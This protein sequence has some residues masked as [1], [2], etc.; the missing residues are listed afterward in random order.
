[1]KYYGRFWI[2]FCILGLFSSSLFASSS[3]QSVE[4]SLN[5]Y[6]SFPPCVPR[7]HVKN[8]RVKGNIVNVYTN[9]T[10][11]C[12]SLS[13]AEL[14]QLHKKVSRWVLG[15][16][17]GKVTLYSDRKDLYS[18]ITARYKTIKNPYTKT[19]LPFI[20]NTDKG[21]TASKGLEGKKIALWP[22]HGLYYNLEQDIWRWQRATM[23]SMVEDV[24]THQLANQWLVPMLENA[25]VYVFEPRERDTQT[26]EVVDTIFQ[27]IGS[28]RR[29]TPTLPQTGSYGIYIRYQPSKDTKAHALSVCHGGVTTHYSFHPCYLDSTWQWLGQT[30]F[31][32][33][34]AANYI[35][36]DSLVDAVRLGGGYGT[37]ERY[38]QTSAM[39][40]WTEAARYWLE[41][42]GYPDSVWCVNRDSNDY[43]D[44]LQSRGYWV[45][46]INEQVPIDLSFALHTDGYSVPVDSAI[47]G[48]LALYT[49]RQNR[50]LTDYIQ[51]QVVEDLRQQVDSTW[52][53]RELRD[54]KYAE[55]NYPIVPAVLLEVLSHKNLADI[56]YALDPKFQFIV[57][58]AIYKGILR[59]L[60]FGQSVVIQPLPVQKIRVDKQ[61]DKWILRWQPTQD[62][63]EPTATP[64]RY[65]VYT[66]LNG[67][68]WDN[69]SSTK[70]TQMSFTPKHGVQYDFKVVAVND[71]GISFDSETVSAYLAPKEQEKGLICIIN[72]FHEV[73]GPQWFTDSTYAGIV[74][75]SYAV[76]YKQGWCYIG[77]QFV[78]D[79]QLDWVDD[80]NCG[81]GM[82]RQDYRGR[83]LHGN[84][85]DYPTLHGKVLAQMGYSYVSGDV[86]AYDFID[87]IYDAIDL[88][89]GKQ[90]TFDLNLEPL[91]SAAQRT[92]LLVSGSALGGLPIRS[93]LHY[94]LRS[95]AVAVQGQVRVT[96]QRAKNYTLTYQTKPNEQQLFAEYADALQPKDSAQV[97]G[98]FS[99]NGL[100]AIIGGEAEGL[101]GGEAERYLI[102]AF[103]LE[104]AT[105][106]ETIYRYSINW[107]T[108]E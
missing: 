52:T 46:F 93:A 77:D 22:S 75:G 64:N 13:P 101:I 68:S 21:F 44:D 92:P 98:R 66:R 96:A 37:I 9:N 8:L 23:W 51:T 24:F 12:L 89:C 103:P 70:N 18:L 36:A 2:L 19:S 32:T 10:L 39:P 105:D 56:R 41:Y 87:T 43:R 106:F 14:T 65:L 97:F 85:F 74:P 102:Y 84:S 99:E 17:K 40:R 81:L 30:T 54:A 73:R 1:M 107:L 76:P 90:S 104:S 31:T 91:A 28:Q 61:G 16:E 50:D 71:G 79:R 34:S 38:G 5:N 63:L 86:Q 42:A 20:E 88:I 95:P 69:G 53:R 83:L 26:N 62:T 67:G 6:V 60:R 108:N 48:T 59:G 82:C 11:S 3:M 58:R 55:T 7:V 15:H 100:P 27:T 78:Y 29:F 33:D 72:A 25:G 49:H 94:D 4:D 80:D 35:L 47:I 45:N 57:S